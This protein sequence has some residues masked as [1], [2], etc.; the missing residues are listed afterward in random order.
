MNHKKLKYA[1]SSF[2]DGEINESEKTLVLSHLK[3]CP[4]CRQFVQHAQLMRQELCSLGDVKLPDSF[5]LR[6]A[7]SL[8]RRDEQTVE[9]LGIEPSARNTFMLLA[10]VVFALFLLTSFKNHTATAMNEQL[11]YKF[12]S[13]TAATRVFLQQEK[14]TK[15]DLLYAVMAK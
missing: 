15:N 14:L 6:L 13:D 1:V 11:F 12:T 10:G 9:W 4:E 7:H 2:V 5:A 8:E 3:G